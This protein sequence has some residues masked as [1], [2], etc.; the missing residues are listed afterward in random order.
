MFIT[1]ILILSIF[2]IMFII[3]IFKNEPKIKAGNI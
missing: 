2:V 3:L 1:I